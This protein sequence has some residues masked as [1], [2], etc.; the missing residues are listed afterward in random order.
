[1]TD[2]HSDASPFDCVD[3]TVDDAIRTLGYDEQIST[4]LRS[5]Y[6]QVQVDVPLR[7]KAGKV[8]VFR[9]YRVQH[10]NSRGPFKGGLRFHP[11]V[12]LDHFRALASLMTWKTALADVPFGG[13]K[14]GVDCDPRELDPADLE[15][16]TKRFTVKM[17][18]LIGPDTDIP[19]PDMGTGPREMAWIYEAYSQ[20]FGL[21]PGAVTGKPLTLGGSEGR[22]EA[23]G[24]G[25]ALAARLA[26][27]DNGVDIKG[28]RIAIQGFGN[29]AAHAAKFLADAG[30]HIIAVSGSAGAVFKEDGLD[31]PRIIEKTREGDERRSV[32]DIDHD[33]AEIDND[34]LLALQCDI[35]IPAAMEGVIHSGNCDSVN[36]RLVVEGA[37]APVT[38]EADR[39]LN[40]RGVAVVPDIFASAGG[41]IVSYLEWVQNRQRYRWTLDRVNEELDT[42]LR[43]AWDA[44]HQRAKRDETTYRTAAYRVAVARVAEAATL[45]GF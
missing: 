13:A 26:A 34:E 12:N 38:C 30:A 9:A 25:V 36:T 41:V 35:L 28:A 3:A 37:N 20:R 29:V 39:F 40:E 27:E 11:G 44:L 21:E 15:T 1:M 16:L 7:T 32:T 33:G 42:H 6:R 14:G 23:T 18:G 2:N 5:P 45:R 22:V 4:L 19:A 10:S 17:D 24:R 31:I 8:R 43:R